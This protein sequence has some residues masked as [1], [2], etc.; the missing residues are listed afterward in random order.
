MRCQE[1]HSISEA[2]KARTRGVLLNVKS[3]LV[4]ERRLTALKAVIKDFPGRCAV[5]V[6]V[7]IDKTADVDIDL[8]ASVR[9]DPC[10]D[11]VDRVEQL[12]GD[13]AVKFL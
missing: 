4:D 8:P 9:L 10:E 6:V 7:H 3:D 12:F 5:R 11:V 2:R 13:G 1:V